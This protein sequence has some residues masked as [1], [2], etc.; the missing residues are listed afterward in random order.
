MKLHKMLSQIAVLLIFFI[1]L[2]SCSLFDKNKSKRSEVV[3]KLK[4]SAK[5]ASVEYVITKVVKAEK[6]RPILKNSYFFA[7]TEAY[8]KAGI[9]LDK[10]KEDDVEVEG[11]RVKLHLPPIEIINFSYPVDSFRLVDKYTT[12]PGIF[13]GAFTLEERDELY[14]QGE[15]SIRE[16]IKEL[17]IVETAEKNTR[18]LIQKLLEASGFEVYVTF[19]KSEELSSDHDELA[20]DYDDKE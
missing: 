1:C 18:N 14:K 19:R 4:S 5:L 6:V 8:I 20:K 13:A 11:N 15:T 17:N 9:D 12:K 16:N 7:H 10:L 3:T 2:S